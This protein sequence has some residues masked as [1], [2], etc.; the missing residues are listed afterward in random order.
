M[1]MSRK[2]C[3]AESNFIQ[4]CIKALCPATRNTVDHE[5]FILGTRWLV[6]IWK[7]ARA[8][9]RFSRLAEK[10]HDY[11]NRFRKKIQRSC[12]YAQQTKV[13]ETGLSRGSRQKT[14]IQRW[15][16]KAQCR[17]ARYFPIKM[18]TCHSCSSLYF[19][20]LANAKPKKRKYSIYKK[21]R[22]S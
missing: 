22:K 8:A 16:L 11:I 13:R 18:L 14:C 4:Q 7:S 1:L 5:R 6:S 9:H 12:T 2:V 21:G 20:A 17:E 10:S 19:S 3:T 15:C